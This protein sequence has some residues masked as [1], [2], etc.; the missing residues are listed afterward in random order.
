ML[1]SLLKFFTTNITAKIL[2]LLFAISVWAYVAT[3]EAKV[4]RFPGRIPIEA[5]NIPI[6]MAVAEDL[7]SVEIQIKAPYSSWQNLSI[8]KFKA[9][10]DLSGLD[11]GTYR[12]DIN[13]SSNDSSVSIVEK[14]PSKVTIKLEPLITKKVPISVKIEGKPAD[15]FAT[16]ETKTDPQD[17]EI[18]GAKSIIDNITT[19]SAV[20]K[21]NGENSDIEKKVKVSAFDN[22][23][24]EAKN[25]IFS[26]D[27]VLVKAT[28]NRATNIKTVGIKA[29]ITGD[30]K[31][32]LWASG[33]IVTPSVAVVSGEPEILKELE[34]LETAKIDISNIGETL[35][36]EVDLILPEGI[37]L[38]SGARKVKVMVYVAPNISTKEIPASFNFTG[39]SG[40]TNATVKVRVS[41]PVSLL[42]NLYSRDV[43]ANIDLSDKNS[44][45]YTI[46]KSD[47]SVPK[48]IDVLDFSP[49]TINI[50][51][52]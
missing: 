8:D 43:L 37:A 45:T 7:G 34:H 11:P 3:G 1:K 41:G 39:K 6:G 29:N 2:A 14:S 44:G 4:D 38:L 42:N 10:V 51:V 52:E 32:N 30:P 35:S 25:V 49:K 18:R 5:K 24:H 22:S 28:I 20:I 15:G 21:L 17:V 36:K 48:G 50:N 47:I 27:T 31:E 12:T 33:V 13:V 46:A 9:E 19:A 40:S 16:T 23:G 26:P